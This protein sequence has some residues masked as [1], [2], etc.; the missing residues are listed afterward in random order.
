MGKIYRRNNLIAGVE[1]RKKDDRNRKKCACVNFRVTPEEKEVIFKRIALSGMLVQEYVAQSCMHN[2]VT[3]VGN[4]K[5][6]DAIRKE[7]EVIDRH[8]LSVQRADELDWRVLESL[9]AILEILDGF[10]GNDREDDNEKPEGENGDG[11]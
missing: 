11:K 5:T 9:R 10:Y 3:T 2:R 7:M 4:I 6:F 1:P 8:L